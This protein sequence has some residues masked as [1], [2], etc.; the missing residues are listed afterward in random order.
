M[1]VA[2]G[3]KNVKASIK[4]RNSHYPGFPF[5]RLSIRFEANAPEERNSPSYGKE[6]F[7]SAGISAKERGA[8]ADV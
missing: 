6:S 3:E 4:R 5:L 7:H 2:I 8:F 1:H